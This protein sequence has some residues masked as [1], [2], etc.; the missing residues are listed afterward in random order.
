MNLFF[1]WHEFITELDDTVN[2]INALC[3][4]LHKITQ[5]L[6]INCVSEN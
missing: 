4:Y 6:E 1:E 3:I 5:F 2:E